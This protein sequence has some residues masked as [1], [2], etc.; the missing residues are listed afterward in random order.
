MPEI[1][2]FLGIVIA[3][4]YRDHPPP[5]FHAAYGEHEAAVAIA[6]GSV[7][8]GSLPKRAFGHV[9]EWRQAHVAELEEDWERARARRPLTPIAPLE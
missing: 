1:S 6:D 9:Q 5:H 8:W 2:R 4:F 3:M 7:L